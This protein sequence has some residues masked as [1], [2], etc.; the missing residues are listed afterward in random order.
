MLV[1]IAREKMKCRRIFITGC[2]KTGTT[3]LRRCFWAFSGVDV[4]IDE[5]SLPAFCLKKTD[6]PVLV[7]KRIQV[8]Q[9]LTEK[10]K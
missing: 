3:L 10:L 8:L 4:L 6:A 9:V 2:A 7:G 5:I 1:I